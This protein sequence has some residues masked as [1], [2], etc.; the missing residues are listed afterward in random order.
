MIMAQ[1]RPLGISSPDEVAPKRKTIRR[2]PMQDR[3]KPVN[4][5]VQQ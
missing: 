5:D 1:V 3:S 4:Y 2:Q